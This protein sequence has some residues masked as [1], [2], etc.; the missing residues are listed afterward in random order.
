MNWLVELIDYGVVG[1][2]LI[3]SIVVVALSIERFLFFK[4]V[5]MEAYASRNKLEYDLS[6]HLHIIGT[7]AGNVP[8]VGLL[9]TVLG[10]MVTFYQIGMTG[11]MDSRTVMVG[12][13]LALKATAIGLAIAIVAVMLYNM[14]VRRAKNILLLWDAA[15][16]E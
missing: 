13:A 8:Y 2:L 6:K 4:G 12:L 11:S 10:I 1:I 9:G 15:H 3:L 14:L 16:E 5:A 7:I